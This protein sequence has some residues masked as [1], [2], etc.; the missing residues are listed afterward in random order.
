MYWKQV[1]TAVQTPWNGE[2]APELGVV[3]FREDF[4]IKSSCYLLSHNPRLPKLNEWQNFT[5]HSLKLRLMTPNRPQER[6]AYDTMNVSGRPNDNPAFH[7]STQKA[8]QLSSLS[9]FSGF[10]PNAS[11]LRPWKSGRL[12]LIDKSCSLLALPVWQQSRH[13]IQCLFAPPCSSLQ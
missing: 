3:Q 4:K 1:T 7:C 10:A 5:L 6:L 13:T 12:W 8:P 2:K 11:H 9:I